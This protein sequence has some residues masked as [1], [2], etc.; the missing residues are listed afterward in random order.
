M[1][2]VIGGLKYNKGKIHTSVNFALY[3][4]NIK[5]RSVLLIDA[6]PKTCSEDYLSWKNMVSP[7]TELKLINLE[8]T[9]LNEALEANESSFDD[10]VIDSGAGEN[11]VSSIQSA[12]RLIVPFSPED[13][14]LWTVW[15]LTRVETMIDNAL[16]DNPELKAFS[17][18]ID[19]D[20]NEDKVET[21]V[22]A[23]KNSQYLDFMS[24][25]T[26]QDQMFA[27]VENKEPEAVKSF[28]SDRD[29]KIFDKIS[30]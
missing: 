19:K 24:S 6:D 16:D 18:M 12:D 27:E 29:M 1:I 4:A 23:L 14:G 3:L 7:E 30:S 5:K 17:L 8:S 2:F 22:K 25:E 20:N 10:I 13:L 26:L 11:L 21:L 9:T 28:I 15:K